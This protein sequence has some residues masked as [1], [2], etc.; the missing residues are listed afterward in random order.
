[1]RRRHGRPVSTAAIIALL[2]AGGCATDDRDGS[3]GPDGLESPAGPDRGD[4][5]V[6]EQQHPDVIA[7]ELEHSGDAWRPTATISSPYDTPR[8]LRRRV[9][10]DDAGRGRARRA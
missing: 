7:A 9:S 1:M 10:R 8:T 2:V 6:A 3:D 4:T 5:E